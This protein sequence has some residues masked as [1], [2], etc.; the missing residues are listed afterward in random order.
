MTN[1]KSTFFVDKSSTYDEREPGDDDP[2]LA[3]ISVDEIVQQLRNCK[4]KSAPGEDGVS[5]VILK[6]L[7]GNMIRNIAL[8][9][10]AS[11]SLGYFPQSWKAAVVKMVP[12][13][14]KDKREVK[15]WRPTSLLPCL[16]KLYERIITNR[17][18]FFLENNDL[19]SPY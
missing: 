6:K 14:G 15:N 4:N 10:N 11:L 17:L 8:I 5:Y 18:T 2:L 12:K 7:P 13:P 1:R 16:G 19:L 3:V 9:F